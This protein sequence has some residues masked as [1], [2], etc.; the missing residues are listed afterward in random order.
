M[1]KVA[2]VYRVTNLINGKIYIGKH[3][4][5]KEDPLN[6]SYLGS[7]IAINRAIRK[8]GKDNFKKEII[9]VC[10]TEQDALEIERDIVNIDFIKREDVYNASVGGYGFTSEYLLKL[11]SQNPSLGKEIAATRSKKEGWSEAAAENCKRLAKDPKWQAATA[12]SNREMV[13]TKRWQD[14]HRA[15][16]KKRS[17]DE[18]W[19]ESNREAG[20]RRA[21]DPENKARMLI[22]NRALS[23]C[24]KWRA[25]TLAAKSK[26][27]YR[28][29]LS[30]KTTASWQDKSIREARVAGI[31]KNRDSEKHRKKASEANSKMVCAHDIT[32]ARIKDAAAALG[33]SMYKLRALVKK[34]DSGIFIVNN[35][36]G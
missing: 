4:A 22:Q 20:R 30:A 34:E 2:T 10:E 8:Y 17:S 27:E 31:L 32:Y 21:E 35:P 33:I 9:A 5:P 11:H 13:K 25:A 6:E 1:S 28:A 36:K 29:K 12:K 18:G 3:M 16:I 26:P 15:A 14:A 24:P 7:G 23:K 19:L